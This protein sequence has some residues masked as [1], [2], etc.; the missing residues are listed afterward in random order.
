M[1]MKMSVQFVRRFLSNLVFEWFDFG[2]SKRLREL[3]EELIAEQQNTEFALKHLAETVNGQQ[4]RDEQR[5]A[6][7]R[8]KNILV[9]QVF[10]DKLAIGNWLAHDDA[11]IRRWALVGVGMYADHMDIKGLIPTLEKM[12]F[13]EPTLEVRCLAIYV[14]AAVLRS[15]RDVKS[16]SLG[17]RFANIV[18]NSAEHVAVRKAAYNALV[19]LDRRQ[20]DSLI[21][22]DKSAD[23]ATRDRQIQAAMI[24]FDR[25]A[26]SF[27]EPAFPHG[28]DWDY[29]RTWQ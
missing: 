15:L 27:K 29:V 23:S 10:E 18:L 8:S 25:F 16:R 5:I 9:D 26:H 22:T 1:A 2:S 17:R 21:A 20:Y 13:Q 3:E 19:I 24:E 11:T 6:D 14:F 28:I 4:L 7:E 12:A